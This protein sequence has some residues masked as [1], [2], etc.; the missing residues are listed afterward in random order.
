MNTLSISG[1]HRTVL[2]GVIAHRDHVI[3]ILALKFINRLGPLATNVDSNL[4]QVR[5][6]TFLFSTLSILRMMTLLS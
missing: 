3:E 5:T 6:D 1:K 4:T 2:V